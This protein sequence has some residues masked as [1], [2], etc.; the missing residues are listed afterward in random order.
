MP[1]PYAWTLPPD[2]VERSNVGPFVRRHGIEGSAELVRRS[3][4]AWA[5]P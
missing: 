3:W 5:S 4:P 1:S 2:A